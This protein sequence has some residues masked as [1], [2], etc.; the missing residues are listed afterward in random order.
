[1]AFVL[2]ET[3]FAA[4]LNATGI[5]YTLFA[6]VDSAFASLPSWVVTVLNSSMNATGALLAYH[7]HP[8]GDI[9]NSTFIPANATATA[10]L[11]TTTALPG[12]N[13]S[14]TMDSRGDLFVNDAMVVGYENATNGQVYAINRVIT[15]LYYLNLSIYSLPA[16]PPFPIPGIPF[17]GGGGG[18]FG[19]G[20]GGAP[21]GGPGGGPGGPGGM[22]ERDYTEEFEDAD[23]DL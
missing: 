11:N 3:G 16:P 22:M 1:M 18:P 10:P 17:G 6:P 23:V 19:G 21:G 20:P 2:N 12:L 4:P 8:G 15:P 13:V 14:L 7:I 9:T 5:R